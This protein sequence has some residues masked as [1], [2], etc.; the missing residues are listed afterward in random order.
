M[1]TA[2]VVAPER[3]LRGHLQEEEPSRDSQTAASASA[4]VNHSYPN[5]HISRRSRIVAA[6]VLGLSGFAVCYL[7]GHMAAAL[8]GWRFVIYAGFALGVWFFV[9]C[10]VAFLIAGA[11]RRDR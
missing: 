3:E 8:V 11:V 4:I 9:A 6:L 10:L 2:K 7:V 1:P 5:V